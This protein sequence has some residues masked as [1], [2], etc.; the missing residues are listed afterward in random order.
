M[1]SNI[2]P[3]VLRSANDSESLPDRRRCRDAPGN[4]PAGRI[5]TVNLAMRSVTIWY[6]DEL[7]GISSRV[8][9]QTAAACRGSIGSSC[10]A[11]AEICESCC[12]WTNVPHAGQTRAVGGSSAPQ[13]VQFGDG[14]NGMAG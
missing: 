14:A 1:L 5:P 11:C 7:G 6:C 2:D 9:L 3:N 10:S 4:G 12:A 13:R 8:W